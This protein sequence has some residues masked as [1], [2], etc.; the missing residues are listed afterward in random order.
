[1]F[2]FLTALLATSFLMAGF[3]P[4]TASKVGTR[5]EA[6]AMVKSVQAAIAK[7][8]ADATLKA[9]TEKK[10]VDRDLYPFIYKLDGT[11]VAHGANPALVGKNLIELKDQSGKFLIKELIAVASGPGSGWVDYYWPN[12][13]TKKIEEKSSYVERAGEY[14]IGV[15]VYK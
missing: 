14:L 3:N 9:V 5:D 7:D 11:N 13:T 6:I 8:G 10:F 12:P 15:G 2:K 1:M 4:A